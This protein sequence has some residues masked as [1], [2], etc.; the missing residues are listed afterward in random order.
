MMRSPLVRAAMVACALWLGGS[1]CIER[2]TFTVGGACQLTS[3][4]QSPLVCRLDRCRVDC[5]ATRDCAA[6]LIC[7]K[8]PGSEV[9]G[10]QIDDEGT[11]TSAADCAEPLVCRFETCTTECLNDTD[12][13][14]GASCRVEA[15]AGVCFDESRN[16]CVFNSDCPDG[17]VCG[18]S[19]VCY[20][21]CYEDRDC[22]APRTCD[23]ATHRCFWVGDAGAP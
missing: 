23:L 7:L 2:T 5:V 3:Q 8:E 14:A 20:V 21:E 9:G 15:D 19:Q 4:C 18:A 11:C 17:S 16:E 13:L 22:A 6:G 10:C 1:G 12:C